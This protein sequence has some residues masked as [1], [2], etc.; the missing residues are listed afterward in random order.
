MKYLFITS[1]A[2]AFFIAGCKKKEQNVHTE[3]QSSNVDPDAFIGYFLSGTYTNNLSGTTNIDYG[4]QAS[5]YKKASKH[6]YQVNEVKVPQISVNDEALTDDSLRYWLYAP[7]SNPVN[8]TIDTWSV[9]GANG[10]NSFSYTNFSPFPNCSDYT[11]LPDSISKANGCAF[12]FTLTNMTWG[13]ISL[14]DGISA[15]TYYTLSPGSNT[16]LIQPYQISSMATG[17]LGFIN[18][19]LQNAKTI[20]LG[21]K[22]RF[23]KE[24]QI[25]KRLKINS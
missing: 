2:L 17:T 11:L 14:G 15:G 23:V 7:F 12:T 8:L 1:L 5:F 18:M 13:V 16:I 10:I 21:Q 19:Q 9:T 24:S 6:I 4:A 22:F 3:D 25:I 20:N